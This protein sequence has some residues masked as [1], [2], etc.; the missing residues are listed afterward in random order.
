MDEPCF[1]GSP[2]DEKSAKKENRRLKV[3]LN[4]NLLVVFNFS[5]NRARSSSKFPEV[6]KETES[7]CLDRRRS[8]R[9]LLSKFRS[10]LRVLFFQKSNQSC[11]VCSRLMKAVWL[12]GSNHKVF[13]YKW[14]YCFTKFVRFSQK[15]LF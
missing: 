2:S 6:R 11:F 12:P 9:S 4:K 7:S 8:I 15:C 14:Y 10:F 3:R 1:A 13:L 5:T